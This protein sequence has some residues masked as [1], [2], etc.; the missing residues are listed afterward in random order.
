MKTTLQKAL[1]TTVAT[2]GL[3]LLLLGSTP[4]WAADMCFQ[5]DFGSTMVGQN[6]AFPGAGACRAFNGYELGTSCIMS[7]AA[8]GTS[9]N[10]TI[11]FHLT[12]TC[13][14]ANYQ[15][16]ANFRISRVNS[17]YW[18]AGYGYSTQLNGGYQYNWHTRTVPCPSPHPLW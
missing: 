3:G 14:W 15:G 13:P 2:L 18:G 12:T 8:C 16:T 1:R 4:T 7:G 11:A 9:D 17:G 10:G 5:D 6:F